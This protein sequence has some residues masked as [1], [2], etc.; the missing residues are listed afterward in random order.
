MK[1]PLTTAEARGLH[2]GLAILELIDLGAFTF[3]F[4]VDS[5]GNW[6]IEVGAPFD[7]PA[8]EGVDVVIDTDD[9]VGALVD[10]ADQVKQKK[11]EVD[12]EIRTDGDGP[13]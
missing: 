13:G 3:D 6:E 8:W 5:E 1:E 7:D 9:L 12:D 2:L 10:L 11:R 4:S